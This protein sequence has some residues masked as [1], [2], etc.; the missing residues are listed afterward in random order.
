MCGIFGFFQTSPVSTVIAQ[1][2][3]HVLRHRGPND[4]GFLLIDANGSVT[5]AGGTDT[6]EDAW[7][8]T[9]GFEPKFHL[10]NTDLTKN[11][12]HVLGHRRLSI[13]D[14]SPQGHQPMCYRE[15]YWIVYNGEIYNYIE[16]RDELEILGHK[17]SSHTD[18]E[19]LLAAYDQWGVD[20]LQRF[21][22]MWSFVLYDTLTRNIFI[23]RDRFGVK[24]FHYAVV[25]GTF[26]FASEPKAIL[27]HPLISVEPNLAYLREYAIN[28]PA[29]HLHQTAFANIVRLENASY[30]Q[31]NIENLV[32]GK[33]ER[34][35][36]WNL[37]P[38]LSRERFDSTKARLLATQYRDLL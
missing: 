15:R 9:T 16:L 7:T 37:T 17:F 12:V 33:F 38:N 22:G 18:T 3:S 11:A 23:S 10:S 6:A 20:C 32:T 35:K 27:S 30:I 21:N 25:D 19:V 28:G 1:T 34:K 24:P 31:C 5:S 29:E 14:L 8:T 36:F 2:M 26:V 4:E 13:Q